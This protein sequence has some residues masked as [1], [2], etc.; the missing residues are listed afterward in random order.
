M[1]EISIE[2]NK[3]PKTA[4]EVEKEI[5]YEFNINVRFSDKVKISEIIEYRDSINEIK[6]KEEKER[7]L[8]DSLK[9]IN[10]L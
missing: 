7:Q 4:E 10:S 8:K 9:S 2:W 3:W 6:L 5:G 1:I